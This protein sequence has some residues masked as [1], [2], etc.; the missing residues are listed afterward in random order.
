[1]RCYF[2]RNSRI[3]AVELLKPGPDEKLIEQAEALFRDRASQG[4]DCFEV[5]IG[6]R[7]V[8]DHNNRMQQFEWPDVYEF[9]GTGAGASVIE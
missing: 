1:M 4:Y 3:E 2:L 8:I 5:W 9:L 7:F 6:R